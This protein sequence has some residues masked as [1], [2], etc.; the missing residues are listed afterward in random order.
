VSTALVAAQLGWGEK[1]LSIGDSP[2]AFAAGCIQAYTDEARW[3]AMRCAALERIQE[4]CSPSVFDRKV[5]EIFGTTGE[6]DY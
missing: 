3:S 1:E 4:E 5:A 2:E 6:A